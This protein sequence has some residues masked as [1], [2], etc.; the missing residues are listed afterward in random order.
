[1]VYRAL[2][3]WWSEAERWTTAN[4]CSDFTFSD[5]LPRYLSHEYES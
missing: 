1:M 3:W 2:D 5:T 4:L